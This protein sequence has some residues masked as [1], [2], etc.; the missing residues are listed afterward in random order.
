MIDL[1]GKDREWVFSGIGVFLLGGGVWFLRKMMVVA[2]EGFGRFPFTSFRVDPS[3]KGHGDGVGLLFR[4][5]HLEGKRVGSAWT[6]RTTVNDWAVFGPYLREPLRKGRYSVMFNLKIDDATVDNSPVIEIDVACKTRDDGDKRL[7]GRTLTPLDFRRS[8]EYRQFRL[9]F[10]VLT[11]ERYLEIRIWS[12]GSGHRITF[13][14][15]RLSRRL[16]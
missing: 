9:D 12:K 10:D 8:D 16:G 11:D 13:D 6:F 7:T 3:L 1:T 14:Y 5:D 2:Y 15:A 4:G